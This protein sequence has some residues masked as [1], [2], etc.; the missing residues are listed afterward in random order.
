MFQAEEE[1]CKGTGNIISGIHQA[2][3]QKGWH[4]WGSRHVLESDMRRAQ[5][6]EGMGRGCLVSQAERRKPYPVVHR[7]CLRSSI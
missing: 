4:C 6:Q 1:M 5:G 7:A 2:F 3:S